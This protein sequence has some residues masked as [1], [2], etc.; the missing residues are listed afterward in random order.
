MNTSILTI[1]PGTRFWGVSVFSGRE[2]ILWKVLNLS[3]KDSPRNRLSQVR[4][5][6]LSLI[7][8][9]APRII[10]LKKPYRFWE[11]QSPNLQKV[12]QEIKF[13]A[14]KNRIKIVEF[15]PDQVQKALCQNRQATKEEIAKTIGQY[16]PELKEHLFQ[17]RTYKDRYQW[18]RM[19]S[20]IALGFCF[21]KR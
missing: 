2:I 7:Q 12:I 14:R 5:I 20:S 16:Y 19:V 8:K 6:F 13:L 18:G 4:K 15:L 9:Y 10:I 21:F 17:S 11:K 1:D 3:T